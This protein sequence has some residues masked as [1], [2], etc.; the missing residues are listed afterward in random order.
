MFPYRSGAA[1]LDGVLRFR[2]VAIILDLTLPDVYGCALI[3][4]M[5]RISDARLMILTALD[6]EADTVQAPGSEVPH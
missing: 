5:R 4:R 2:P 6:S 1:G 3:G